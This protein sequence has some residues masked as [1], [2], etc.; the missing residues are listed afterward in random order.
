MAKLYFRYGAMN[1]GKSALL[2]QTIHN[3]EDRNMKVLV[4]KPEVDTKGNKNII[5]RI[6]LKREADHIIKKKE[7][8]YSYLQKNINGISC[9]FIDE[10]QFLKR[11]QVDELMHIVTNYDI[12]IICY[13][14]R[15]DFM[16]NGFPGST[17]L[18]EIAHSIEEMKTICECGRKATMNARI[19]NGKYVFSGEQVAIDGKDNI[20]YKSLCPKCYYR[21]KDKYDKKFNK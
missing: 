7:N 9:I 16:G 18:L 21:E 17:R 14:L 13:G 2:L 10:A 8:L 19:V 6:G 11:E 3:Y 5:S 20:T 12:P 15:T 1:C 4:M